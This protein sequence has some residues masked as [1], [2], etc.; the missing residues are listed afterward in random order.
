MR[1][2]EDRFTAPAEGCGANWE[3]GAV[4]RRAQGGEEGQDA[5]PGE[6]PTV[7]DEKWYNT[8]GCLRDIPS[9]QA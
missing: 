2:R 5:W 9:I 7:V 6:R 4:A 1:E 8:V 3:A